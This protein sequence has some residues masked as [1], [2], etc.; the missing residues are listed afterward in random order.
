[1][2]YF[3]SSLVVAIF[4]LTGSSNNIAYYNSDYVEKGIDGS[5]FYEGLC[6]PV[7]IHYTAELKLENCN[8]NKPKAITS[9][10]SFQL[11]SNGACGYKFD[12]GMVGLNGASVVFW[13]FNKVKHW[14]V[15]KRFVRKYSK[16]TSEQFKADAMRGYNPPYTERNRYVDGRPQEE[17][18]PED[19]Q[20]IVLSSYDLYQFP[21]YQKYIKTLSM[22]ELHIVR[23]HKRVIEEVEN[24]PSW[25]AEFLGYDEP[26]S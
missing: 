16:W 15:C 22:Y 6:E 12:G 5:L 24:A 4:L 9:A 7:G 26:V 1:M 17:I 3:R 14:R 23:L 18:V 11:L 2:K 25:M 13:A 10:G 21:E 20:N 19:I 8:H